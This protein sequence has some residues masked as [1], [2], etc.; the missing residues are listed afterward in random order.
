MFQYRRT[1]R[2]EAEL[3]LKEFEWKYRL[4][5][6]N[7]LWETISSTKTLQLFH[8][9]QV[10]CTINTIWGVDKDNLVSVFNILLQGFI[11]TVLI[12]AFI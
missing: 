1:V 7:D 5:Y 4:S 12:M 6:F 3:N 11:F 2:L 9:F 8:R 10:E